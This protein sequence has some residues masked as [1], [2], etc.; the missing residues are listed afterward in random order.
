MCR[1]QKYANGEIK[2]S[3]LIYKIIHSNLKW[4][5]PGKNMQTQGGKEGICIKRK[6]K[7]QADSS[8]FLKRWK[9][10]KLDT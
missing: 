7:W 10:E 2:R 6:K 1:W 3:F 5:K 8:F 4:R 9:K